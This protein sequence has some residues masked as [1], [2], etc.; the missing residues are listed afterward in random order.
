MIVNKARKPYRTATAMAPSTD[1][2][3]VKPVVIGYE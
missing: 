3:F 1:N 2:G